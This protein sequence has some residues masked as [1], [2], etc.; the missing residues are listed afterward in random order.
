MQTLNPPNKENM[1]S[2]PVDTILDNSTTDFDLY[3]EVNNS[4][5]LYGTSPYKWTKG[6]LTRLLAV[7]HTTL[8]YFSADQPKVEVYKKLISIPKIDRSIPP[9]QRI[10][11]ITDTAAELMRI[12]YDYPLTP[13]SLSKGREIADEIVQCVGEDIACVGALGKLANHDY[14]TYYHSVRMSAYALAVALFLSEKDEERL[15]ELSMGCLFHDIGKSRI[16]L[17]VIN[18]PGA[19]TEREWQLMRKHPEFGFSM[20]EQSLLSVVPREVIMH[21]HERL[22]GSGYP[23]G[24]TEQELLGEVRIAAFADVFDALTSN[25]AYQVSR[26]RYEA[27]DLIRFTMLNHLDK[28][29]YRAMVE[30]LGGEGKL[31]KE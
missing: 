2:L 17:S 27:L 20:V 16:E 13:A 9:L 21:H 25:R 7:G 26:T 31:K 15:R 28:K 1:A 23:H 11:N 5:T 22:D 3:I 6:E 19:L 4:L 29:A 30:I 12:L 8:Y 24:L 10:Q 14:Y 18:K